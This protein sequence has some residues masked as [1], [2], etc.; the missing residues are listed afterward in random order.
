MKVSLSD[1]A[2]LAMFEG[3]A[4]VMLQTAIVAQINGYTHYSLARH[5]RWHML[6]W[7]GMGP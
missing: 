6:L 4:V 7:P 2:M 3:R 5:V 1:E